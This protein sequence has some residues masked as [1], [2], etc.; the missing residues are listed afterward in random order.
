MRWGKQA[1]TA[2]A[3]TLADQVTPAFLSMAMLALRD[4]NSSH[5]DDAIRF[6]A[7]QVPVYTQRAPSLA[8]AHAGGCPPPCTYLGL[9]A[10]EATAARLF[11]PGPWSEE[12]APHGIIWI[13]EN[14]IRRVARGDVYQQVHTT[15]VH[16]LGHALQRDH[17]LDAM[18]QQGA[19]PQATSDEPPCG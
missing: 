14:G 3:D 9:W 10:D 6:A 17:V 8:Q 11:P 15:L 2:P 12:P 4:I 19:R 16:E 7:G 5:P 1:D 18:E 13:F